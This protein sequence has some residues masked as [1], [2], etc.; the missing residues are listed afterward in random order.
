MIIQTLSSYVLTLVY[1]YAESQHRDWSNSNSCIRPAQQ[2]TTLPVW[3]CFDFAHQATHTANSRPKI[4]RTLKIFASTLHDIPKQFFVET[5][6]LSWPDCYSSAEH[7]EGFLWGKN[8]NICFTVCPS[9]FQGMYV[10]VSNCINQTSVLS[11]QHIISVLV[12]PHFLTVS[13]QIVIDSKKAAWIFDSK[14]AAWIFNC[15]NTKVALLPS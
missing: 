1:K 10:Q 3:S 15:F 8:E 4:P 12:F 7:D 9:S 6:I 5:S 13:N 2:S 11:N 14:K